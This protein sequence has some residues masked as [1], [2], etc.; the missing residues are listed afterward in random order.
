MLQFLFYIRHFSPHFNNSY[1]QLPITYSFAIYKTNCFLNWTLFFNFLKTWKLILLYWNIP[2][3]D[4]QRKT[5]ETIFTLYISVWI[6]IE[7]W[8]VIETRY[9]IDIGQ[10]CKVCIK[11]FMYFKVT[12]FYINMIE[13][14]FVLFCICNMN[15]FYIWL[16]IFLILRNIIIYDIFLEYSF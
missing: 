5:L 12:F 9:F 7:I 8:N 6:F 14:V 13:Y 16:L 1:I 2:S 10:Q 3:Q 4:T 11:S 15:L